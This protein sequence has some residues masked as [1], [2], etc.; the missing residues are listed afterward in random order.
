MSQL[1]IV[2]LHARVLEDKDEREA[3]A[4]NISTCGL[5]RQSHKGRLSPNEVFE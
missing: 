4:T 3:I 1:P 5:Q 2:H